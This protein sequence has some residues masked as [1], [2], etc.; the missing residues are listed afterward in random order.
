M[1]LAVFTRRALPY[2]RRLDSRERQLKQINIANIA[3]NNH[4]H[5]NEKDIF[6]WILSVFP[7]ISISCSSHRK[8]APP[9]HHEGTIIQCSTIEY[10]LL[11]KNATSTSH[12]TITPMQFSGSK[13]SNYTRQGSNLCHRSEYDLNVPP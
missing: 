11:C 10:I 12:H 1:T 5:E 7:G 4:A 2:L 3:V 13:K 9:R 6:I 8:P